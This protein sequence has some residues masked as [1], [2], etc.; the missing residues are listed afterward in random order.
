MGKAMTL[1]NGRLKLPVAK[2]DIF[3]DDLKKL[4]S[5]R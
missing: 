1:Y 4:A 5:T 3:F 2:L